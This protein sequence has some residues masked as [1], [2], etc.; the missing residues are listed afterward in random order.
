MVKPSKSSSVHTIFV[1]SIALIA[2][3]VFAVYMRKTYEGFADA[4]SKTTVIFYKME[5]CPHC[6]NFKPEW[7][8]FKQSLPTGMDAKE[9]DAKDAPDSIKGFPTITVQKGSA[10]PTT[11]TGD[12]KAADLTTFIKNLK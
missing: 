9:V 7:E 3:V 2:L 12:R 10:P 11:Y 1:V 6:D 4:S 5:G 8:K